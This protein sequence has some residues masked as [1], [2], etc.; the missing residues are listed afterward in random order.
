MVVLLLTS[1][2]KKVNRLRLEAFCL[3]F[4]FE[5]FSAYSSLSEPILPS[6]SFLYT[7]AKSEPANGQASLVQTLVGTL[8]CCCDSV[9]KEQ[10]SL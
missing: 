5:I 7:L 2:F 8:D 6:L 1:C 3:A 10:L 9:K 4:E